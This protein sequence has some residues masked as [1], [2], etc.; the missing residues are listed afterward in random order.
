MIDSLFC[1]LY[2]Q[3]NFPAPLI[4]I[5]EKSKKIKSIGYGW[6]SNRSHGCGQTASPNAT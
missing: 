3:N 5:I 4:S 1:N 2:K 6:M